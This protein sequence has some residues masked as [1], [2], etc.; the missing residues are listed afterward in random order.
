MNNYCGL[1]L[2]AILLIAAPGG[3]LA[4]SAGEYEIKAAFLYKF[5][6]F[7]SWPVDDIAAPICIGVVGQ[8][9]FGTAL[10]EA[11][12]GKL[13]NG[14]AFTVRRSR[15]GQDLSS[16]QIVFISSSE[17]GPLRLILS[18]LKD[19]VLTVGDMPQFC[20]RG[21]IIGFEL[22]DRRVH[23]RINLEAA[24]RARLQIS[25]KLLSLAQLVGDA[26]P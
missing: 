2:G 10:D 11:V 18:K 16:C 21:G 13:L 8:D 19:A 6:G 5:A 25:S 12:R 22:L 23:L 26:R 24:Q 1:C 15:K 20:E 4:Q 3:L 7:V 14:R 9:P 17:H